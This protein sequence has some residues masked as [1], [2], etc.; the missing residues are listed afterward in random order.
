MKKGNSNIELLR[1]ISMI[2]IILGHCNTYG[3]FD[4]QNINGFFNKFIIGNT[5]LGNLGV[6]IFI[7]TTGYFMIKKEIQLKK[8][9]LFELQVLFYSI[10]IYVLFS[11]VDLLNYDLKELIKCFFPILTEQYWF[12]SV[13]IIF[14]L[15]IPYINKLILS[16]TKKELNKYI[17]LLIIFISIIPTF[18]SVDILKNE[19]LQFLLFY[20]LGA[21]ININ[22]DYFKK[23][24]KVKYI[25]L[26][27][28]LI[29]FIYTSGI[30]IASNY[31][32]NM[33]NKIF[34][35]SYRCSILMIIIA[36][37]LVITF[38]NFKYFYSKILNN[39]SSCV[40][41][42]YLIHDN[43]NVRNIIWNNVFF[44]SKFANSNFLIIYMIITV[45][46]IFLVS[47]IVELIRKYTIE[48]LNIK[49]VNMLIKK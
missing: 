34:F 12:F 2:M 40:F 32:V 36:V 9:I 35:F 41:G 45:A 38:L 1:I 29:L 43:P 26:L 18:L 7:V 33:L 20:S 19:F 30:I 39:I 37:C 5:Y 49:C 6:I 13:Y 23:N 27:C 25:L 31:N 11:T 22:I 3:N 10:G 17:F 16:L 21:Y 44:G 4:M 15:F 14:Y 46:I 8:I 42:I 24:N 48:R 28:V 47:L